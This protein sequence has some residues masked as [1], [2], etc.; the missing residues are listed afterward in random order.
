MNAFHAVNDFI[1]ENTGLV[2]MIVFLALIAV[3]A[4]GVQHIGSFEC[5]NHFASACAR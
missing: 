1:A 5:S 2:W 3:V 4:V